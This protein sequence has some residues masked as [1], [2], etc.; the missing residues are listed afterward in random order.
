MIMQYIGS[1]Q[2]CDRPF[3][4]E[5]HLK[6]ELQFDSNFKVS[7]SFDVEVELD[8]NLIEIWN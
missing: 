3:E 5:S 8:S 1:Y 6:V 7:S 4:F 2:H